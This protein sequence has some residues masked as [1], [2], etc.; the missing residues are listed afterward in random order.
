[1]SGIAPVDPEI[2]FVAEAR[3]FLAC[4]IE[5]LEAVAA[6]VNGRFEQACRMILDC[7]GKV[8]VTG[9]GKSG[10][11][12]QKIA[13][14]MSSTGTVAIFMHAGDAVHG[15]LGMVG[16]A[17]VVLA[18]SYSGTTDELLA[19]LPSIKEIGAKIIAMVGDPRSDLARAADCALDIRVPAEAGPLNLAPTCS[20]L[21]AM[22]MG[23]ALATALAKAKRFRVEQFALFHPG[24]S[25]GRRLLLRVR[26]LMHTDEANPVIEPDATI[27]AIVQ[28]LTEKRLGGVSVVADRASMRLVGIVTEGDLRRALQQRERFFSLR[29]IDIMTANPVTIHP[30]ERAQRALDLME[31]LGNGSPKRGQISVLSVVDEQGR[32]VGFLRLHDLMRPGK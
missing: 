5:A 22:A 3:Q 24:G 19:L 9:V 15:D 23:D 11:I 8:V 10:L 27:E 31:N 26:D 25:V 2:D 7:R 14:T 4:E 12:A 29:A 1:M 6:Q 21:V 18:I 28:E 30:D 13:A 32:A 17:D 16:A 20:A